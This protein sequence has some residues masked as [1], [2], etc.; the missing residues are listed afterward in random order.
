M[1]KIRI[2]LLVTFIVCVGEWVKMWVSPDDEGNLAGLP[3]MC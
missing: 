3:I 2:G 1:T